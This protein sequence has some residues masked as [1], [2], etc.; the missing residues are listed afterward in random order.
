MN[1]KNYVPVMYIEFDCGETLYY[2]PHSFM[3]LTEQFTKVKNWE[4]IM[5]PE[6]AIELRNSNV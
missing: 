6:N 2:Q 3:L 1:P 4:R 5:L